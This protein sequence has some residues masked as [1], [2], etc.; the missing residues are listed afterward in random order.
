MKDK[1]I[2]CRWQGHFCRPLESQLHWEHPES[3]ESWSKVGWCGIV[4]DFF[5]KYKKDLGKEISLRIKLAKFTYFLWKGGFNC[6]SKKGELV[7]RQSLEGIMNCSLNYSL[8]FKLLS[9]WCQPMIL[10]T[11]NHGNKSACT[12]SSDLSC[13]SP[14][15]SFHT[16]TSLTGMSER[17]VCVQQLLPSPFNYLLLQKY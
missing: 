12:Q 7:Q 10:K 11:I 13:V 2:C 14:P 1:M 4:K 3:T 15:K 8:H 9:N 17:P 16:S 6:I 5:K